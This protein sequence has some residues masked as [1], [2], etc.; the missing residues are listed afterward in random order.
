MLPMTSLDS[1]SFSTSALYQSEKSFRHL[2]PFLNS[3]LLNSSSS[4]LLSPKVDKFTSRFSMKSHRLKSLRDL[5]SE[6]VQGL[7]LWQTEDDFQCRQ[8]LNEIERGFKLKQSHQDDVEKELRQR[9]NKHKL[10]CISPRAAADAQG[11]TTVKRLEVR[12]H[13]IVSKEKSRFAKDYEEEL[14]LLQKKHEADLAS[15]ALNRERLRTEVSEVRRHLMELPIELDHEKAMALKQETLDKQLKDAK[16]LSMSDYFFRRST[17]Q[18]HIQSLAAEYDALKENLNARLDENA[19]KLQDYDAQV[20]QIKENL[21]LIKSTQ[22]MHYLQLL[23]EGIDTRNEGLEWIVKALWALNFKVEAK[24]FPI[25]LDAEA[26]SKIME[27]A[28]LSCENER[29]HR[30][31]DNELSRNRNA[32]RNTDRW[33][34]ITGRLCRIKSNLSAKCRKSR[35]DYK[36]YEP[37]EVIWEEQ[38]SIQSHS[39]EAM[40]DK[41]AALERQIGGLRRKINEL[42]DKEIERLT[43][44]CFMS[45]Y[46]KKH[47]VKMKALLACVVGVDCIDRYLTGINRDQRSLCAQVQST[48]TFKFSKSSD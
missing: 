35:H 42:K 36:P 40:M 14:G 20:H 15:I 11:G 45:N 27:S 3:S 39:R 18:K 9:R 33:N 38:E 13:A 47:G 32:T 12:K 22:V 26:I 17:S 24:L 21:K 34:N 5:P 25:F 8:Q 29:V 7:D 28:S 2:S 19:S 41:T 43:H 16:G 23:K 46:E 30:Q 1:P 48:K 6:E 44:A 4:R 10:P 37:A 31:L